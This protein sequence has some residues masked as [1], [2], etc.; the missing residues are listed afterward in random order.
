MRTLKLTLAYDGAAYAGWQVQAGQRT[1]LPKAG[2][3]KVAIVLVRVRAKVRVM[4]VARQGKPARLRSAADP[5][6]VHQP[7][8]FDE[9]QEHAAQ[10]PVHP[11]LRDDLF[12]PGFEGLGSAL[13]ITGRLPLDLQL[14]AKFGHFTARAERT[15]AKIVFQ[16][17]EQA[18][19][20]SEQGFGVDHRCVSNREFTLQQLRGAGSWPTRWGRWPTA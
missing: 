7:V 8:V 20:V 14:A 18:G 13:G 17:L 3:Q 16:P 19:Q 15:F 2:D 9:A 4:D 10:Q 5:G 1:S 12:G 6:P 11:C